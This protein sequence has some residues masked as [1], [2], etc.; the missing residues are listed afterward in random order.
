MTEEDVCPFKLNE[1]AVFE[2]YFRFEIY[3]SRIMQV[4]I[5]YFGNGAIPKI[6]KASLEEKKLWYDCGDYE[7]VI[8]KTGLI[9]D[10]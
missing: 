6:R 5:D 3:I 1:I 8:G 2:S 4:H 7:L 9:T 10:Y